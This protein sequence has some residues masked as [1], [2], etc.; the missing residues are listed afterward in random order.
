MSQLNLGEILAKHFSKPMTNYTTTEIEGLIPKI[1]KRSEEITSLINVKKIS[2]EEL[3]YEVQQKADEVKAQS[4]QRALIIAGLSDSIKKQS[5]L[6]AAAEKLLTKDEQT[7]NKKREEIK[8]IESGSKKLNKKAH[9]EFFKIL[10]QLKEIYTANNQEEN[11][12]LVE[13][14]NKLIKNSLRKGEDIDDED[15]NKITQNLVDLIKGGVETPELVTQYASKINKKLEILAVKKN[16]NNKKHADQKKMIVAL[17][18]DILN[19]VTSKSK[20]SDDQKK[21]SESRPIL[22]AIFYYFITLYFSTKSIDTK[23]EELK[24]IKKSLNT[25]LKELS[26]NET[27]NTTEMNILNT[28]LNYCVSQTTI[29]ENSAKIST[30]QKEVDEL[31]GNTTGLQN[32]IEALKKELKS[33]QES[34]AEELKK[35]ESLI[36]GC[37]ANTAEETSLHNEIIDLETDLSNLLYAKETLENQLKQKLLITD[38]SRSVT[39]NH[40]QDSF[41]ALTDIDTVSEESSDTN[42]VVTPSSSSIDSGSSRGS[43]IAQQQYGLFASSQGKANQQHAKALKPIKSA[44]ENLSAFKQFYMSFIRTKSEIS[45]YIPFQESTLR[46]KEGKIKKERFNPEPLNSCSNS[47]HQAIFEAINKL[48]TLKDLEV[49]E[50][51]PDN[52]NLIESLKSNLIVLQLKIE[53]R[54]SSVSSYDNELYYDSLQNLQEN[55]LKLREAEENSKDLKSTISQLGINFDDLESNIKLFSRLLAFQNNEEVLKAIANYT[56]LKTSSKVDFIAINASIEILKK[57]LKSLFQPGNESFKEYVDA[58]IRDLNSEKEQIMQDEIREFSIFLNDKF[59]FSFLNLKKNLVNYFSAYSSQPL[60]GLVDFKQAYICLKDDF[61]AIK[62]RHPNKMR[63]NGLTFNK[64]LCM[65][66]KNLV[67]FLINQKTNVSYKMKLEDLEESLNEFHLSFVCYS[68]ANQQAQATDFLTNLQEKF[69]AVSDSIDAFENE[70]Q[71][72]KS[73]TKD[74]KM[75]DQYDENLSLLKSLKD[76]IIDQMQILDAPLSPSTNLTMK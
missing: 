67:V 45:R 33:K 46:D 25:T 57:E 69:W 64:L 14:L 71:I 54:M 22:Y 61:E 59:S 47:L 48:Q 36:V 39:K 30:L 10:G 72:S 49:I 2:L 41:D 73:E 34:H 15:I 35:Q 19:L 12:R 21:F 24:S 28:Q 9:E 20:I 65:A 74:K 29:L 70:T 58:F 52:K 66:T 18:D 6:V 38:K 17:N 51:N 56:V 40:S 44:S 55:L 31:V 7:I 13:Q 4:K 5:E 43:T 63:D 32:S 60:G 50:T 42:S 62:S 76:V 27:K 37:D 11:A 3:R 8:E 1:D 68:L 23:I 16:E 53:L 26:E 75:Q